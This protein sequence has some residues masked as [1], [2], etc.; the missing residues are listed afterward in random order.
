MPNAAL[1]KCFELSGVVPLG[2]Y[3]VVHVG[4]YARATFGATR[5]GISDGLSLVETLLEWL[6]VWL[7]FA[8]H[9]IYGEERRRR[10]LLR[11]SGW[12][13]LAFVLQHAWWLRWPIASGAVAAED[14]H[15][16]L[17]SL[18][19]S[20]V[21]GVPLVAAVHLA[22]LGAVCAHFAWGFGRFLEQWGITAARPARVGAGLLALVLFAFGAAAVVELAT[23]SAL[24]RFV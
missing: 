17:A 23:G 20:T 2:V 19:S 4:A 6:L 11:V 16:R 9:A 22:G 8:F 5:F 3:L 7:P 1:R 12:L 15:E 14:M 10:L 24:P 18:L 13:S 21:S